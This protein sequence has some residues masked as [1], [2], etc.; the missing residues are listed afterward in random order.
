MARIDPLHRRPRAQSWSR[1]RR[2]PRLAHN[3][4]KC[5]RMRWPRRWC[6]I[7]LL[8]LLWRFVFKDIGSSCV[9]SLTASGCPWEF[10]SWLMRE[11][12]VWF[13]RSVSVEVS[14]VD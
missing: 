10:H 11:V 8:L 2:L 5:G 13:Y 4:R 7:L 14:G 1:R 12:G 6:K 3:T 9:I